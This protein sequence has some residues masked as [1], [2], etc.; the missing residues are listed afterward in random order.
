MT[1]VIFTLSQFRVRPPPQ[2]VNTLNIKSKIQNGFLQLT[3][4]YQTQIKLRKYNH[5]EYQI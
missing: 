5:V 2:G 1:Q 3:N 4:T